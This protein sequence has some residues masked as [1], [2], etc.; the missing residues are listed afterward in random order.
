MEKAH[1]EKIVIANHE[2]EKA[3][4]ALVYARKIK[5]ENDA[6]KA[7]MYTSLGLLGVG[8][9]LGLL[10]PPLGVVVGVFFIYYWVTTEKEAEQINEAVIAAEYALEAAEE[11]LSELEHE[12]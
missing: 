6:S 3:R 12:S 7:P 4:E 1:S 8:M 5:K 2:Y 11:R 10:L 9:P